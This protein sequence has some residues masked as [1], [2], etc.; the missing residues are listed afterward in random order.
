MFTKVLTAAKVQESDT[1]MF[2]LALRLVTQ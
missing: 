1:T 2:I